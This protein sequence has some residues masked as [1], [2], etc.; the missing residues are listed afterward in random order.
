[1]E[2]TSEIN[3][4]HRSLILY[5]CMFEFL[6][7]AHAALSGEYRETMKMNKPGR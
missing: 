5:K 1:M 3:T 7:A 6:F 4:S 2:V